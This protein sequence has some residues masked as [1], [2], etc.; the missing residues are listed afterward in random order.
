MKQL[1]NI[2]QVWYAELQQVFHNFGLV[3]FCILVPLAY[4]LLYTFV[5]TNE[6]VSDVPIAIVDESHS[7]LSRQFGRMVDACP[8]VE[9]LYHCD[10][11]Q[12]QELMRREEIYAIVRIP[13]SF[14]SDLA[15]GRQTYIGLYSDMRCMLYYKAALL[16]A[17]NVSLEMNADIKV[18]NYLRPTTDRQSEIM[19]APVTSQYIALYNPQSGMAS[20]LIPAVLI[21]ILQQLLLLSIGTSMGVTREANGGIGIP[22]CNAYYSNPLCIVLG[23]TLF[24]LP[25][26]LLIA[27]YMYAGVTEWFSLLS[28]GDY[29]TFLR[30]IFPYVLACVLLGITMSGLIYRSEDSMMLFVFM[31]LPLLF[32]SGMSW[33]LAAEPKFW[34][35]V[36]WLFPSSFGTHGYARIMGTGAS[37]EDVAFEYR[38]LWIQC[39]VY[40]VTSCCLYWHELRKFNRTSEQ[41]GIH[42]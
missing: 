28:L 13:H 9:V 40:F 16:S 3:I 33:P 38:S 4:P 29:L 25:L 18:N 15:D 35:Y 41:Y 7:S 36:S 2:I 12:A 30:F 26:F 32:L 6:N 42:E 1:N 31:S 39:G 21:L 27:I 14:A 24:Y 8:E 5:Y 37:I 19:K 10:L 23:K 20:F 22:A 34:Q 17:T 11:A